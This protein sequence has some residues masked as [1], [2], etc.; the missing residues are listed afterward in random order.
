[1]QVALLT[2]CKMSVVST[3]RRIVCWSTFRHTRKQQIQPFCYQTSSFICT[4]QATCSKTR[5][6]DLRSDK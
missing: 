3:Y 5:T 4:E 2:S 1:V 6:Q